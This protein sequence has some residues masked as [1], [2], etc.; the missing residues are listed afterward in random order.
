VD[1]ARA[2]YLNFLKLTGSTKRTTA[3]A[4]GIAVKI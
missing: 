3:E 4:K 2:S 1:A